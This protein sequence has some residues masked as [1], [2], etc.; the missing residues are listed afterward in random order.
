M[1]RRSYHQRIIYCHSSLLLPLQLQLLPATATATPPCH[2]HCYCHCY[3]HSS[4]PLL[5]PLPLLLPL[6]LQLPLLPATAT[7]TATATP[8]CYSPLSNYSYET[9]HTLLKPLNEKS[10]TPVNF[11]H[12]GCGLHHNFQS[13]HN[14]LWFQS[15][16]DSI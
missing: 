8:P 4:L 16:I 12:P 10:N 13:H 14:N 9:P 5:M 1:F 11:Q 7:A 3:C 2:C 6:Q 15:H